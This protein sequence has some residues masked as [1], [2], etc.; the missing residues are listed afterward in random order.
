MANDNLTQLLAAFDERYNNDAYRRADGTWM[1]DEDGF[2]HGAAHRM[3]E[4]AQN[5]TGA[6]REQFITAYSFENALDGG[7]YVWGGK[8]AA[9]KYPDLCAQAPALGIRLFGRGDGFEPLK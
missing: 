6:A 7:V 5:L 2:G 8:T 1:D 9:I 4:A 3:L